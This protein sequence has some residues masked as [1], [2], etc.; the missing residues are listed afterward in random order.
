MTSL[1]SHVIRRVTEEDLDQ[2]V[3]L[4]ARLEERSADPAIPQE[5]SPRLCRCDFTHRGVVAVVDE[6]V[7][8]YAHWVRPTTTA[9]RADMAVVVAK[10]YENRGLGTALLGGLR[11]EA[12]KAGVK[13]LELRVAR[14][15]K[16]LQEIEDHTLQGGRVCDVDDTIVVTI[17]VDELCSGRELSA[18]R[19][20][21]EASPRVVGPAAGSARA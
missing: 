18:M 6:R 20:A 12:H 11:R 19:W 1:Q 7:V 17:P 13:K 4:L 21:A 2:V 15:P 8:G 14:S 3:Q 16:L 10:E 9:P 5:G